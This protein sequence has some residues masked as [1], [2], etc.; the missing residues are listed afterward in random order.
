MKDISFTDLNTGEFFGIICKILAIFENHLLTTYT[1]TYL[2][3]KIILQEKSR[4]LDE[5]NNALCY[6]IKSINRGNCIK[7]LA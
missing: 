6:L 1:K 3:K 5:R 7:E 2:L 4:K